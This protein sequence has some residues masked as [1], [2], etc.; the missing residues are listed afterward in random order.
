MSLLPWIIV[1][2]ALAMIV[3]LLLPKSAKTEE[4]SDGQPGNDLSGSEWLGGKKT[5]RARFIQAGL[6]KDSLIVVLRIFRVVFFGLAV[7]SGGLLYLSGLM[8][9]E[10]GILLGLIAGIT[11]TIAPGFFLDYL[12][13]RRKAAMRRALPDALDVIV[14]CLDGGL[15][16]PASFSSV[17]K[18]L[19]ESHPKL[20]LEL[21]IVEREVLMGLSLADSI[22]NFA[23]RFDMEELRSL[24]AVVSQA[25]QFGSSSIRSFQIFADS[26]RLKRQQKA[27]EIAHKAAVKLAFPTV[28]FILPAM[29]VVMLL[30][31]FFQ[32]TE[33]LLPMFENAK[34]PNSSSNIPG[35]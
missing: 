11:A 17:A 10:M 33:I 13:I 24:A 16:L 5:W 7:I 32:A 31:A 1:I 15:T 2:F 4:D 35:N 6:Y 3:S 14:V 19:A 9:L 12:K 28:I 21:K 26:I 25:N 23:A 29:L 18:E 30:P 34:I 8:S 27:E 22:R 20:A